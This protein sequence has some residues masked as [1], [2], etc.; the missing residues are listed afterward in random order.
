MKIVV[1]FDS[2]V[3]EEEKLHSLGFILDLV[4]Q[5]VERAVVKAFAA[6]VPLPEIKIS[7]AE[8]KQA[9]LD[10]QVRRVLNKD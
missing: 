8:L 4:K 3:L 5:E 6:N 10:E 2:N 1:E 7:P 9:V